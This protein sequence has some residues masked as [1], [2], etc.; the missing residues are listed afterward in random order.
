[1]L[2]YD[3]VKIMD[4]KN[5]VLKTKLSDKVANDFKLYSILMGKTKANK[6]IFVP[7]YNV[8]FCTFICLWENKYKNMKITNTT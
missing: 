4:L 8:Y 5:N 7:S 6:W 3:I 2:D 1:M